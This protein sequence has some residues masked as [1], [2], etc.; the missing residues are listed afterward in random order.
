MQTVVLTLRHLCR[1]NPSPAP[2]HKLTPCLGP[3]A[4]LT[5]HSDEEVS[6]YACYALV[7]AGLAHGTSLL[8]VLS[9][10]FVQNIDQLPA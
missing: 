6:K 2:I 8:T 4:A 3:L 9:P 1:P 10:A 5:T 7:D